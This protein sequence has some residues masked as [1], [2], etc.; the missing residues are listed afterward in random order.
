MKTF[1]MIP[2]AATEIQSR[3]QLQRRRLSVSLQQQQPRKTQV[4][5]YVFDDIILLF[6]S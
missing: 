1:F 4:D 6:V 2:A 3:N 5:W